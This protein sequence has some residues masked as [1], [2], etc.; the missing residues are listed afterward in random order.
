MYGPCHIVHVLGR[1]RDHGN[2]PVLGHIDGV[3][4]LEFLYLFLVEARVTE[5][6]YLVG[7]VTPVPL[8]A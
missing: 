5:H 8:R 4:S 2:A 3:L 7:H 6:A 1:E